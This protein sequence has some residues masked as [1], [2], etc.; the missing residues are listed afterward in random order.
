MKDAINFET[1]FTDGTEI[2]SY[3]ATAYA[4]GFEQP[5]HPFDVMRA[6]SYLIGTKLAY[7][8]Q[9]WFGRTAQ[10]L[11]S[12]NVVDEEG[13]VNWELVEEKFAN[14]LN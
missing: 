11:I 8:L 3:L 6:W 10:S 4:E 2:N 9:G 7:S 5:E 14:Q 1:Q 12:A 13:V